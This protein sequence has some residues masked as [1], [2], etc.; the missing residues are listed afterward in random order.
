MDNI[1]QCKLDEIRKI[2][3]ASQKKE[4]ANYKSL[5]KTCKL[6]NDI[7]IITSKCEIE[8][9]KYLKCMEILSTYSSSSNAS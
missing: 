2:V 1:N 5:Y 4:C 7:G 9:K 6:S 3:Y 8:K